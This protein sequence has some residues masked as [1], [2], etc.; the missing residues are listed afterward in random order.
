MKEVAYQTNPFSKC[1]RERK[2]YM[3]CRIQPCRQSLIA[4]TKFTE[5]LCLRSENVPNSLRTLAAVELCSEGMGVETCPRQSL[6]LVCGRIKYREYRSK[7]ISRRT[8]YL[9]ACGHKNWQKKLGSEQV[10]K[11]GG[12][13][14]K[15]G[16]AVR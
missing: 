7:V 11:E 2:Q 13:E 5:S 10:V 15:G 9:I 3:D 8:S 1:R 14:G 12:F 16:D 6:V 4:F